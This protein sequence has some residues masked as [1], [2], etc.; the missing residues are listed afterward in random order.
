[1]LLHFYLEVPADG[2][3]AISMSR[4]TQ[5]LKYHEELGLHSDLS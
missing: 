1:M 2:V 4:S 5:N 3:G